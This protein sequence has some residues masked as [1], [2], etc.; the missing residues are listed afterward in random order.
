MTYKANDGRPKGSRNKP[1][2]NYP[3]AKRID[4]MA[5][6]AMDKTLRW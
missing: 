6:L 4:L 5:M 3:T 1:K 2:L